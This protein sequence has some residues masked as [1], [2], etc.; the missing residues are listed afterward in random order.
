MPT[1]EVTVWYLEITGLAQLRPKCVDAPELRI[2]QAKAPSPEFSRFLYT[3][4]GGD[5]Y[6]IER[7]G[8][9]WREWLDFLDRPEL[10]TWVAWLAGTPAGYVE[11][12]RQSDRSVKILFF[13][14]LPRFI[15]RGLARSP[16]ITCN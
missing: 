14:L 16:A 6:W 2:V 8:W 13:G 3:A 7:L 1:V 4:V 11:L 15:G 9:T 5:I 10:E 12:E